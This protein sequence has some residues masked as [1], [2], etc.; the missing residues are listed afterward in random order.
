M[1]E[2]DWKSYVP[3]YDHFS[4]WAFAESVHDFYNWIVEMLDERERDPESFVEV[5]CGTGLLVERLV[6]WYPDA[7]FDL[8]DKYP[9]MLDVARE[10]ISGPSVR[11]HV[12][13]SDEFLASLA[14]ESADVIVFCRSW[15][16]VRDPARGAANALRALAP[17]GRIFLFDLPAPADVAGFERRIA[18]HEPERWPVLRRALEEFNAGIADGTYHVFSRAELEALWRAAGAKL[19][20]YESDEP[21]SKNYRA[22]FGRP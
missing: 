5:G 10:R 21:R 20:A 15:F 1:S 18:E 7:S 2:I 8:A 14:P 19:I 22:C 6:E 4:G 9:A 17:D 16:T 3:V 13:D 11:F 12:M